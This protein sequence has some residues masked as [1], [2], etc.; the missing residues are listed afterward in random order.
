MITSEVFF[1]IKPIHSADLS[2]PYLQ[3]TTNKDKLS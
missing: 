1:V 2:I 3:Q